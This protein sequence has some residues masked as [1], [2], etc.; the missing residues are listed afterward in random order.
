MSGGTFDYAQ[1]RIEDIAVEIEECMYSKSEDYAWIKD[2]PQIFARFERA[3]K[4]LRHAAAMAQRID[5]LLAGDDGDESFISR[6]QEQ[7]LDK[8]V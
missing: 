1:Y 7:G 4:V 6:W 3:V 5:W 2:N 8:V